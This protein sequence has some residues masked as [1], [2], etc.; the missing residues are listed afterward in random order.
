MVRFTIYRSGFGALFFLASRRCHQAALLQKPRNG[1][2]VKMGSSLASPDYFFPTVATKPG[3]MVRAPRF[4]RSL[5]LK[6]PI[7]EVRCDRPDTPPDLRHLEVDRSGRAVAAGTRMGG[8]S[9][10]HVFLRGEEKQASRKGAKSAKQDKEKDKKATFNFLFFAFFAPLHEACFARITP[11]AARTSSESSPPDTLHP[12]GQWQIV[13]L[14]GNFRL[15]P[16]NARQDQS[17]RRSHISPRGEYQVASPSRGFTQGRT[18]QDQA[19]PRQC[20]QS[21]RRRRP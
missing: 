5:R 16:A 14:E 17:S 21:G 1:K 7:E 13:E 10:A 12:L 9:P 2:M 15:H 20:A 19:S 6:V 4:V 3:G 8:V 18:V 11:R